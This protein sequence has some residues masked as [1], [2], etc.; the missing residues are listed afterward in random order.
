M[1]LANIDVSQSSTDL[2]MKQ[3]KSTGSAY[4]NN[5]FYMHLH[6]YMNN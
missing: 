1:S 4:R 3:Q 5:Y 6:V 2:K